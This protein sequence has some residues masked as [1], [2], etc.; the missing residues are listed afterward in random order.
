MADTFFFCYTDSDMLNTHKLLYIFPDLAYVVDLLPTK[1]EHTFSIQ[2]FRQIN[3]ELIKNEAF[4]P[5]RVAKL[6]AKLDQDEYHLVL[7]DFMF[8]NTIVNVEE[9]SDKKIAEH[10]SNKL[11][12]GLEISQETH[13]I[14]TTVLTQFK[15]TAK[16][17]LSALEHELVAPVY[18]SA[19]KNNIHIKG[20]SS[21]SWTLK[22]SISLEPSISVLQVGSNLYSALHYIG[23]DQT[24][25]TTL[26]DV[27]VIAETIKTL[28]GAEPSIQTIYLLS[29]TVVEEQLKELLSDTLPIQ[30]LTV[31]KEE[32]TQMPSYVKQIIE[33]GMKTLS[34]SDFP[35]PV[36]TLEPASK[37]AMKHSIK[38]DKL[39]EKEVDTGKKK[40]EAIEDVELPKPSVP[41][42]VEKVKIEKVVAT[43][44]PEDEK[45]ENLD[46]EEKDDTLETTEKNSTEQKEVQKVAEKVE[47]KPPMPTEEK[48]TESTATPIEKP[49]ATAATAVPPVVQ[50][51]IAAPTITPSATTPTPVVSTP[52]PTPTVTPIAP[53]PGVD[54]S[55]FAQQSAAAPST[56]APAQPVT[57]K[58]VIK[59]KSGVQSMLKM[60]FITLAVFAVTVAVGIGVGMGILS[61][62]EKDE[63]PAPV[64]EVV[65]ETAMPEESAVPEST[66]SAEPAAAEVDVSE[67]SILVVNATGKAGY[68]G[69]IK[70]LLDD[71]EFKTVAASNAKGEYEEGVFLLMR[72]EVPGL[73]EYVAEAVEL[74][75]KEGTEDSTIEDTKEAYD[76]V[77]VL[78][79]TK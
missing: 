39:D 22:S 53:K 74:D 3:G 18:E 40:D 11:L 17:Q 12:P 41:E 65:Q 14:S 19:S 8:T 20:I 73:V 24:N 57:E 75:V 69:E 32:D 66:E 68:A 26:D 35:V 46:E 77:L 15:G 51:P 33:S 9:D 31:F 45:K 28:K 47:E 2:S 58:K 23:V 55:Q 71:A 29:N 76:A 50:P 70:S 61:F 72:E 56:T 43:E 62:S 13:Q 27:S 5:E 49:Q 1:K 36:F 59:N 48:T 44:E 67:M 42:A 4:V 16:V 30:Q 52:T 79:D 37:D 34:I 64:P 63:Q 78:A 54:V 6:C 60:V 38:N 7:P 10:I 21:L 25:I